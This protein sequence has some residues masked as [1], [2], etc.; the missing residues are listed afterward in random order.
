MCILKLIIFTENKLILNTNNLAYDEKNYFI[1]IYT[2]LDK[3][4]E[5]NNPEIIKLLNEKKS[6][7]LS[8]K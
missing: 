8:Q 3:A 2:V 7:E 4:V 1:Y 6:I 5:K